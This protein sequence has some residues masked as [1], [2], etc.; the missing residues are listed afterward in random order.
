[1]TRQNVV[2]GMKEVRVVEEELLQL[3]DV[4]LLGDV[5]DLLLEGVDHVVDG[6]ESHNGVAVAAGPV[7]SE[8]IYVF[9]WP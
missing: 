2:I 5:A 4:A 7:G 8:Y 1:M 6:A 3:R 9:T